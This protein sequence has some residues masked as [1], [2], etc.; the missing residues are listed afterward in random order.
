MSAVTPRARHRERGYGDQHRDRPGC[1][2]RHHPWVGRDWLRHR[3]RHQHPPGKAGNTRGTTI[4]TGIPRGGQ[5]TPGGQ[6][7]APVGEQIPAPAS[8]GGGQGA[9][10]GLVPAPASPWE[11]RDRHPHPP[12]DGQGPAAANRH[13][14]RED[15]G[16]APALSGGKAGAGPDPGPDYPHGCGEGQGVFGIARMREAPIAVPC[17]GMGGLEPRG[18]GAASPVKGAP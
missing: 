18:D 13:P 15:T 1:R 2:Y 3:Y 4:G 16:K 17:A 6:R 8:P 12:R 14:P 10:E 11:V 5:G 9:A 7:W